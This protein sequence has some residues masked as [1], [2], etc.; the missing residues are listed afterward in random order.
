ME[1]QLYW[2]YKD[3]IWEKTDYMDEK[4]YICLRSDKDHKYDDLINLTYL[5]E[6][7]ILYNIEYRYTND[8][9][10]TFNGDILLAVN[11]F[12]KINIYNDIFINNYNLKPYIDLKPHPYYIGKKA[13]EK[14]KYNKNQSILVSGESGAGKTQTTKII[15]KY[16]S[17]IC[18]N[19]KNDISEKILASNPILEA[20]G[21]AKTIRNDNSSRFGK[22][23]KLLFDKNNLIGS[24]INT[25]LLE[26]IRIT[27]VSNNE[28]NFHI[29]YM[30]FSGLSESRRKKLLLDNIEDYNYINKSIIY[31]RSD[32]INDGTCFNELYNSFI[33]LDFRE[34]KI[35]NIFKTISAILN[36]GNISTNKGIISNKYLENACFLL[37]LNIND[38][39]DFFTYKYIN[40]NGEIIKKTTT[41]EDF[42]IMRD[43]F[44]QLL[45]SSMFDNIVSYINKKQKVDSSNFIGILDIFG[46]E[47]FEY[48]GFEQLCINYTNE[49]LQE[50][51]NTF[52]F[53]VEQI[54]YEKEGIKWENIKY[55]DNKKIIDNFER[56][57]TGL[58]SSLIEQCILK[59]G[60]DKQFYN[61]LDKNKN[62]EITIKTR[63]KPYMRFTIKHYADDVTYHSEGFIEKNRN[64]I[65][66]RIKE[67]LNNGNTF[68]KELDIPDDIT[69]KKNNVIYH[70]RSQLNKLLKV[71]TSTKQHYIRCIKPNDKNICDNFNKD[72]VLEQL[73]YCGIMQAIKIAKAGYPIRIQKQEFIHKF[74]TY[75][76]SKQIT[77]TIDNI[78]YLIE[79][80]FEINNLEYQLG[81]SKVFMK[82]QL[83]DEIIS[84]N[85]FII[86]K[87][88]IIIQKNIRCWKYNRIYLNLLSKI[89]IIQGKWRE[90]ILHRNQS[91]FI[92]S[93]FMKSLYNFL[94]YKKIREKIIKIQSFFRMFFSMNY[95]KRIKATI[96]IQSIC[97]Q[98]ISINQYRQ[99][100]Y[101]TDN[102][103]K[104]QKQWR[105]NKN[106][107]ILLSNIKK[108]I[109]DNNAYYLLQEE[110]NREK[111]IKEK[112]LEEQK[113]RERILLEKQR[114]TEVRLLEKQREI[115]RII[116]EKN[117]EIER[118]KNQT[119]MQTVCLNEDCPL[120]TQTHDDMAH[121]MQKLYLK[122]GKAKEDLR[123]E[124]ERVKC[125]IM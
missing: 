45:Y 81:N 11:P 7:S 109:Q 112:L 87:K 44:S 47:V 102:A 60:N 31:K 94:I 3:H 46:F 70:F 120:D 79:N 51:F 110:L 19:D 123:I 93:N 37:N 98:F 118:L 4:E 115:D 83:Y 14:L 42:I 32:G 13:F 97:R 77:P 103:K 108:I 26:K 65:D 38:M 54:E 95:F 35:N 58:F 90:R 56:K 64:K 30:L 62:S 85:E 122:L 121:K 12:K 6:P 23:I 105:H 33:K 72:R 106:R 21:N 125:N 34:K 74:Y 124:Q 100:V 71:I 73:R 111:E 67:L 91:S 84:N 1:K 28:R 88:I 96:K 63:D 104:I 78:N 55:P 66:N 113:K 80:E 24:E 40:I 22:F 107:N 36:L 18:S 39:I 99:L 59:K 117:R 50:L 119:D 49:K 10:Y 52:I 75:M 16:I 43:T 116:L 76:N 89:K 101:H 53:E 25:Y 86:N 41:E 17:N 114:E 15:M 61:T 69:L 92:I 82:K 27:N 20:F 57:N 68:I 2:I 8:N 5:N 48:N 9:I 29:F